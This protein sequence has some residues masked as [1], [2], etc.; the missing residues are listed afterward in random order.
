MKL[1]FGADVRYPS[2]YLTLLRLAKG[3]PSSYQ[4]DFAKIN[5]KV[6]VTVAKD[7]WKLAFARQQS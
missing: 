6:S 4:P 5:A 7:T 2:K 1:G 3:Q